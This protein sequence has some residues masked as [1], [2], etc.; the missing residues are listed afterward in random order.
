M[1]LLKQRSFYPIYPPPDH[2]CIDYEAWQKYAQIDLV[3]RVFIA[4]SDLTTFNK[5]IYCFF[6]SLGGMIYIFLNKLLKEVNN[7]ACVNPGRLTKGTSTG[8]FAHLVF[9]SKP[10]SP[11]QQ[12]V[13]VNFQKI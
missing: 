11:Y 5:V 4:V 3:P 12:D 2:I 8:G 1:H 6:I 13:A 9:T 7:C 10:D